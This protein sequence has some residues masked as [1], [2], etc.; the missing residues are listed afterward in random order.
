MRPKCLVLAILDGWGV[1]P[2][3][4]GNAISLAHTPHFNSFIRDYPVMSLEAAGESVGLPWGEAGNSEVGH[5]AIGSGMVV[6]H[7]FPRINKAINNETYFQNKVL[8]RAIT[9]VRQNKSRLHL[10]G[11]IGS[12]GVHSH[13]SHLYAL[14]EL[15]RRE[16][17]EDVYIHVILDGR[18]APY[19]AGA[20]A[21]S[22]LEDKISELGVGEIASVIGRFYAMDRDR[23]W[24]RVSRAFGAI[25][26]GEAER[27]SSS[28]I[29]AVR[30]YYDEAIFDEEM[31]AIIV[32]SKDAPPSVLRLNDAVIFFNFRADRMRELTRALTVPEFDQFPR[33]SLP[34]ELYFVTMTEYDEEFPVEV[35]FPR[36]RVSNPVAKVV[37][38]AGLKQLHIAETEKYAHITYFFNGGFEK[39]FPGED[40]VLI[41]SLHVTSYVEAPAM[42]AE[43]ITE[44]IVKEVL[45]ENYDLIV[46]NF[47]NPDMVGHTG[48]IKATVEA[49]EIIDRML[50]QISDAVLAKDGMMLITADHGNAEVVLNPQT[51]E[52]DKEHNASSVPFIAIAG[53]LHG[54]TA[55]R[56]DTVGGDLSLRK[57][58]GVLADVAPTVLKI[59]ELPIPPEMTGRP[60]L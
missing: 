55:G 7:E 19:N 33:G 51:G 4:S 47:A 21:L 57:S 30:R 36:E 37:S 50:G 8:L 13:Q 49:I 42:S 34:K 40:H 12:G 28:A 41:P 38:D 24:D 48:S 16:N 15:A 52:I 44:R 25:V 2:P 18:D 45:A 9:T 59:L 32:G 3:S 6:Y 58:D 22:R 54:K 17:I 56:Q 46:V 10:I 14:L 39:P 60:L 31:P 23:H 27:Y 11:L 43:A 1:A 5:M 26:N 35:A 20:D 53:Q 29:E